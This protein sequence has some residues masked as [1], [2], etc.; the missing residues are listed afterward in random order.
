[1]TIVI[2]IAV[3]G[4]LLGLWLLLM[5]TGW[6]LFGSRWTLKGGGDAEPSDAYVL[7][8]RVS[9]VIVLGVTAA[10]AI[11]VGIVQHTA[12]R[13]AQLADLWDVEIRADDEIRVIADPPVVIV[14]VDD[15]FPELTNR[16]VVLEPSRTAVVG[17]DELGD[18]GDLSSFQDGDLAVGMGHSACTFSRL[19]VTTDGDEV[20]EVLIV[21]EK[22]AI[23]DL[24]GLPS[25]DGPSDPY[26]D[27]LLCTR[28]SVDDDSI[29]LTVI[30]VPQAG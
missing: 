16:D 28:R 23:P 30:R 29:G 25:F 21:V 13:N 14:D 5:R 1:M 11:G 27:L 18:L 19:I 7:S 3:V 22:A 2:V 4:G 12:E 24:P 26:F 15:E 8:V 6:M 20:E 17:R 9:G 10:L